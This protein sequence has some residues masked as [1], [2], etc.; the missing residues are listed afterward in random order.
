LS[1]VLEPVIHPVDLFAR[2]EVRHLGTG[3][4]D[5]AGELVAENDWERARLPRALLP[6]GLPLELGRHNSG[7][8]D[9]NQNLAGSRSWR[10]RFAI[11]KS[12]RTCDFIQEDSFHRSLTSLTLNLI[13]EK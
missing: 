4:F 1:A 10:R 5:S 7:G 9:L 8:Q 11:V 2:P 13:V 12:F 3:V 6:G